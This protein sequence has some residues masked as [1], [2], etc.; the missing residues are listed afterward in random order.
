MPDVKDITAESLNINDLKIRLAVN[1]DVS[2]IIL[3]PS[4]FGIET[5]PI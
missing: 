5:C 4:R 1:H 3:L 2:G